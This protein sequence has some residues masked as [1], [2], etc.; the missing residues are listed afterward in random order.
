M[1]NPE[2]DNG[3]REEEN[4]REEG[5]RNVCL[6]LGAFGCSS[7][8]MPIPDAA[9]VHWAY[10]INEKTEGDDVEDEEDKIGGPVEEAG[11]EWEQKDQRE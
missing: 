8:A 2:T 7:D 1:N 4:G 11:R 10:V 9:A 5:E 6:E 3:R